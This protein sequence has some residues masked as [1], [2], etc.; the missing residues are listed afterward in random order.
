MSRLYT[1]GLMNSFRTETFN[2]TAASMTESFFIQGAQR[3]QTITLLSNAS[4]T[5]RSIGFRASVEIQPIQDITGGF[6][7]S[8]DVYDGLWG[9]GARAVQ[10]SCVEAYSQPSTWEISKDGGAFIRGQQPGV[11]AFGANYGEYTLSF[12]TKITR[13]GT[14]W[15]V[16]T[17]PNQGYGAYFVLTSDGPQY[18]STDTTVVPPNSLIAGYG[19]SIVNFY[20]GSATPLYYSNPFPILEN[21]WYRVST[22][23]GSSGYTVA[24]NGTQFAYVPY[25]SFGGANLNTGSWGFGPYLDQAAYFKDVEVVAQNGTV[26]YTNQLTSTDILEEY[27]VASNA[28]AVCLDGAKRDREIWIGDFAHTARELAASTGRYDFIQSMIE[29]EFLGQFTSGSAAG[30]VP[31]QNSMGSGPQ[32]EYQSVYYPSQYGETDYQLFFLL[33]LGDYFALTSDTILYSKYWSRIKL[34]VDAIVSDYFDLS[35]GLLDS[36]N[37]FWFTAPYEQNATAP[38]AL[39]A[40]GLKQ[41]AIVAKTLKDTTTADYY[42][43]LYTNISTA[44]NTLNWNPELGAYNTAFG[45]GGIGVLATA[46]TIRAGIANSSQASSSIQAL[47]SL[48]YL[49][50]YKDNQMTSNSPTTTL[51]PNTQ[52]FLL[53]S[54]FIAYTQL[55]VTADIVVPV[56][57]NLLDVFWPKMLNQNEYYSGAPWEYLYVDGSPGIGL[58]TSLCHPWGGAPTYVLSDYVLGVRREVDTGGEYRWVF[59]P[60]LQVLQGLGLS[61]VKGR[62]PLQNEGWIEAGWS[63]D[64]DGIVTWNLEVIGAR[65]VKVDVKVPQRL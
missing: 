5:I 35:T 60:P 18:L 55:N 26:L 22:T 39:F 42:T 21:E 29:Y 31:I 19:Y 25:S 63:I 46:F 11:S 4:V 32:Y 45:G 38:T 34:L 17:G 53:E 12:S 61:W 47:S 2:I 56:L 7:S 43:T 15:K 9:L 51:S 54:L 6:S 44:I 3:W 10:A 64:H 14:G 37:A 41:L 52:G 36:S 23:I 40:I 27:L 58:F 62:V 24:V 28:Y 13:G 8:N 50:G 1:N 16:A 59:D 48:F 33:T 57:Q 65:G 30:I 20:L 49:I